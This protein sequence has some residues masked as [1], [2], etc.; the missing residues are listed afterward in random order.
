MT[1]CAHDAA[2]DARHSECTA[3]AAVVQN[4]VTQRTIPESLS[5]RTGLLLQ[6]FI[7]FSHVTRVL[8]G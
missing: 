7:V 1:A 3:T 6:Q 5:Q 4:S 2:H 8:M